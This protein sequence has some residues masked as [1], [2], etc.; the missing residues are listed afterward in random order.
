MGTKS[1]DQKDKPQN[2]DEV[3]FLIVDAPI[4]FQNQK[5][6]LLNRSETNRKRNNLH[7]IMY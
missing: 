2:Y 1:F 6:N 7:T 4:L 5:I 3:A